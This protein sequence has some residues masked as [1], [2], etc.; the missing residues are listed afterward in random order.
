MVDLHPL[1]GSHSHSRLCSLRLGRMIHFSPLSLRS[2]PPPLNLISYPS[3]YVSPPSSRPAREW[4][5]LA[6]INLL[7]LT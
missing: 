5:P 1:P 2:I 6:L 7:H 4:D 3:H